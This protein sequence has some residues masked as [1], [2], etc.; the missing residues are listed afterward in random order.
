M[1]PTDVVFT[2]PGAA[3]LQVGAALAHG[4]QLRAVAA[5]VGI[6]LAD[7][8]DLSTGVNPQGWP[9]PPVPASCWQRLPEEDDGLEVA[10]R[11][12]HGCATLLPV[13]GSQAAL[14][15]LPR[16]RGHSRVAL[17]APAYAEHAA[18]WTSGGHQVMAIDALRAP[19]VV[20][21]ALDQVVDGTEVLILVQPNNP[22]GL[23]FARE[24]L[25][26][27]HR[28]LA[29]RGGWLVVDEAF[30]DATPELSLAAACPR[31]GL[32]VLRSLG[33]FFGL[34]GARVGFVLAEEALLAGLQQQL[35]PW[36]LTGPARWVATEA[37]RDHAWQER[38]RADLIAAG[39]RLAE[40]LG[41][42]GLSPCGG[43]A[44][45]A[46]VRSDRAAT[47]WQQLTQQGI[48]T[49]L[50]QH[51]PSLRFG[52]PGEESAW[53]RLERGLQALG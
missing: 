18:A 23:R 20:A 17:L 48:L 53:Q 12:Y 34:A 11:D 21:R 16:L 6:P 24:R 10:A 35:G 33:K 32:V 29:E 50:F 47:I 49:R 14:Q 8:L 3:H 28:R 7:W 5:A 37:L 19:T 26:D 27:W 1:R 44:L 46:W 40:L 52:L 30:V 41:R 36:T 51:P 43:C 15:A 2:R 42:H 9:V 38:T 31:P 22:S 39:Q 45:F 13:A 4:G 25:L